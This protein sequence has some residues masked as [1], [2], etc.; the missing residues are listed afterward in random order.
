MHGTAEEEEDTFWHSDLCVSQQAYTFLI[1]TFRF[2][3][4][5]CYV[6]AINKCDD[7]YYLLKY[8]LQNI[9]LL[10]CYLFIK[11]TN[12]FGILAMHS[13]FCFSI[14]HYIQA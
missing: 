10:Y 14:E 13:R 3:T 11:I 12:T 4:Y 6:V 8:I 7:L 2:C 1:L 9:C 5:D